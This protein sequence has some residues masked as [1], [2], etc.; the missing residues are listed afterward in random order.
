MSEALLDYFER[1]EASFCGQRGAPLL[2]SPLDFEKAVEWHGAGIPPEVVEEGIARYFEKLA[3]R[4]TPLRRAV[5][6]FF[7]EE[8]ILKVREERRAA[9]VGRAAGIDCGG[10]TKLAV[11]GFLASRLAALRKF[12][13]SGEEETYPV[14]RRALEDASRSIEG[15][16]GR[17]SDSLASLEAVLGPMDREMGNLALLESPPERVETWKREA[18]RR[19]QRVGARIDGEALR[20]LVDRMIRQEA[21]KSLGLPRLSLLFMESDG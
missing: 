18:E 8:M 14:L 11:E 9:S 6:L 7:S 12:L 19:L 2:L 3:L 13:A 17:G 15:L 20:T 5:C 10:A 1:I 21:M 16:C 4:K